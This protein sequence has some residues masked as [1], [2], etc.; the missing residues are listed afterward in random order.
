MHWIKGNYGEDMDDTMT[1]LEGSLSALHAILQNITFR[2]IYKLNDTL[3][4]TLTDGEFVVQ[5]RIL[6]EYIAEQEPTVTSR[7]WIIIGVIVVIIVLWLVTT[8]LRV[9][10]VCCCCSKKKRLPIQKT[11]EMEIAKVP[12]INKKPKEVS[13]SDV[14]HLQSKASTMK[15]LADSS[16]SV[17]KSTRPQRE[18]S[19][20]PPLPTTPP[21]RTKRT[22]PPLPKSLPT[23]LPPISRKAVRP[24]PGNEN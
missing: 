1:E 6:L 23:D 16:T 15:E 2:G 11:K 3:V 5:N 20:I 12:K 24:S 13:K 14:T 18:Q 17:K 21:V 8:L 10:S 22:T 7:F 19:S 9:C 4:I